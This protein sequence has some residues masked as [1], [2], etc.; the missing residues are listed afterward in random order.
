MSTE[1]P[2][3]NG[4]SSDDVQ[5]SAVMPEQRDTNIASPSTFLYY[6][7]TSFIFGLKLLT[8][9]YDLCILFQPACSNP[10]LFDKVF[11]FAFKWTHQPL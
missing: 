3:I 7:L 1:S 6:S 5:F 8:Y 9:A 2:D 10:P 11:F 4:K